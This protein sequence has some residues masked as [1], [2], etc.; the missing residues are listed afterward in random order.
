M[1]NSIG[2]IEQLTGKAN[3]VS[4][5]GKSSPA[6]A[7]MPISADSVVTTEAGSA[8]MIRFSDGTTMN[9]GADEFVLID[10]TVSDSEE[11]AVDETQAEVDALKAIL[12]ESP[13][14]SVF[15]ETASGE[16]VAVGGS[17]LIIDS[18]EKHND[19]SATSG[20][21]SLDQFSSN[22]RS[23]TQ[24]EDDRFG[25]VTDRDNPS[26]TVNS[27]I[28][29]SNPTI[30]GTVDDS[31]AIIVVVIEGQDHTAINNGDGSWTLPNTD[32]P[33]GDKKITV[34]ATDPNGNDTTETI[35]INIDTIPPKL[36]IDSLNTNDSTPIITGTTDKDSDVKIIVTIDAKEHTATNNG[37]GTWSLPITDPLDEG[38][39]VVSVIA[40]DPAGND[41]TETKTIIVDTQFGD[42]G[43]GNSD[44]IPTVTITEDT[45][46][47][48]VINATELDGK[49]DVNIKIPSEA[50]I[51]DSIS[52]TDGTTAK[53]IVIDATLITAG[54]VDTSFD[55]PAQDGTITVTA[56][57]T[58]TN[59][60][61]ISD[62]QTVTLDTQYGD[63]GDNNADNTPRVTIT[64]D[65]NQDG[66]INAT[67]LDGK[68]DV[69]IKIPSEAVIGDIVYVS[70]GTTINIITIDDTLIDTGTIDTNFDAPT[71]DGT[72][73]ITATVTDTNGNTVSDKQTVT[74]DTQYGNT[75]DNNANN[76]PTVTILTDT[77]N[78]GFINAT[79]LNGSTTLDVE[80]KIPE[81]AVV[82][83]VVSITDGK[84][85]TTITI[86]DTLITAGSVVT[87]FDVPAEGENITVTATV[88]DI[89][90]NT[91]TSND[92]VI[93]DTIADNGDGVTPATLTMD[94]I[95]GNNVINAQESGNLLT[96]TGS[97][98]VIGA[99]VS[100][101]MNG[102]EFNTTTVQDDG[103]YSITI[104]TTTI[105]SYDDDT[106]TVQA[107]I[108]TDTAGNIVYSDPQDVLLDT[109]FANITIDA[110]TNDNGNTNDFIT[111][112]TSSNIISGTYESESGNNTLV[113]K[114]D[115]NVY[116][117]SNGL[118]LDTDAGTW[119]LDI[120]GEI[121][122]VGI[123]NVTAIVTDKAGNS[124]Q[125]IQEIQTIDPS[126]GINLDPISGNYINEAETLE[127]VVISGTSEEYGNLVTFT[128]DGNPI[129]LGMVIVQVDGTFSV[130]VPPST[131]TSFPDKTY[132][133][134]ASVN[135]LTTG[136][137]YTD[138]EP[139]VL[140]TS[141]TDGS[142]AS[143]SLDAIGDNYINQQEADHGVWVN[144]TTTAVEGTLISF[145]IETSTGTYRI[146]QT[147]NNLPITAN[148]D[149]TFNANITLNNLTGNDNTTISII[150][151]VIADKAG[152]IASST[153][154]TA[155]VDLSAGTLSDDIAP[156]PVYES[157]LENGAT[158]SL[159]DRTTSGNLFSNDSNIG[160]S[161]ISNISANGVSA[162][163][164]TENSNIYTLQTES[165]VIFIAVNDTTYDG[166]TYV[167][168]DYIYTLEN[169]S[170]ATSDV[171]SYTVTDDAGNISE[172]ADLNINIVDG[173]PVAY[174]NV[175][176]IIAINGNTTSGNVITDEYNGQVDTLDGATRVTS[177]TYDG[178]VY[179][180]SGETLTINAKYGDVTFQQDGSYDYAYNGPD[181]IQTGGNRIDLWDNIGIYAFQDD[182]FL[183]AGKLD[184]TTLASHKSDVSENS[185]G[186]GVADSGWFSSDSIN[187]S[188]ALVL[189]FA[190]NI[191]EVKLN[192]NNTAIFDFFAGT[193]VSIY[194]A[195]GNLLDTQGNTH[196]LSFFGSANDTYQI[197]MGDI[198][199]KYVVVESNSKVY[200][201]GVS[202]TPSVTTTT[203]ITETFTYE[204]T[205]MD[206]DTSSANLTIDGNNNTI[207]YDSNAL[208][209]DSGLG[210]DTLLVNANNNLDFSSIN[211]LANIEIIDLTVGDHAIT[212]LD[213]A[214]IMNMTD[215]D[216]ILTIY[217]DNG[218][219][220]AKPVGTS[221]T[222]T[223]VESSM[224]D[225][226]GHTVDVYNVSDGSN[227]V[228]VNI[229]Q[230]I[231]V[232]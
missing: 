120:T 73:T 114:I 111:S 95:S 185:K 195:K 45:N 172:S 46:Q 144:G 214:D 50:V 221:E 59:G 17:S 157:A 51:G 148:A 217:G 206:G 4:P 25:L 91:V 37:D 147:S 104:D 145:S 14:L 142:D 219:S 230:E 70:D 203:D 109:T 126:T 229:E 138:S 178:T 155:T 122:N 165:G 87:T 189:E 228:T 35:V 65:T 105:A 135:D 101:T 113:I 119:R 216:N 225:G 156:T 77:N 197:D 38:N 102:G 86:T 205:D 133:V 154:V 98:N 21:S 115:S 2:K 56:T 149:G 196:F 97:S 211:N 201:D 167:A 3:I 15:E 74:I 72:I 188:D 200:V 12:A 9:I 202:Y 10:K 168:G 42:N 190:D 53:V 152:N 11:L 117:T 187:G 208:L 112:D 83:D 182:D 209:M 47:D 123:Y 85:T 232:S 131:F 23:T 33:Q 224:D 130:T 226:N 61:T 63:T 40:T 90:G 164:W 81:E 183:N 116:D 26:I 227:T 177:I 7:G 186:L 19:N 166:V 55:A 80:I 57:V 110:M 179:N 68:I 127:G 170:A 96:I 92:S 43:N 48:G 118:T 125:A 160:N 124:N 78:D 223:Q 58:D 99:K 71:E 5:D 153:P 210:L 39:T 194:D 106:Y 175:D 75:G 108:V 173:A 93:I 31:S 29:I 79:E 27:F 84:S 161:T 162:T 54:S 8:M 198:D 163:P 174:D 62:E 132:I 88:T 137:P 222:W 215:E 22:K 44:N 192:I 28:N 66:V 218:D 94:P 60:N 49:I 171:I 121:E 207:T 16:E 151:E 100:F 143:I 36:T 129:D 184:S 20:S 139:V 193:T 159:S 6:V 140:D 32:L 128:I 18:I 199:F 76:T 231:V 191:S 150:A 41:T 220:V 1:S 136:T 169:P 212:N 13:D 103:T 204:I 107:N 146:T 64:E 141:A 82:N 30:N 134:E 89:D 24:E 180:F 213:V 67:E 158:P 34:I 176:T 52:I 69:N 181:P